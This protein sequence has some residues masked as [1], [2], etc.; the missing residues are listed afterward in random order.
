MCCYS[1]WI[2]C[3]NRFFRPT[4]KHLGGG[5]EKRANGSPYIL[6]LNIKSGKS[7][8]L[9]MFFCFFW[10]Q[11][12]FLSAQ[13]CLLDGARSHLIPNLLA[14]FLYSLLM[15][16]HFLGVFSISLLFFFF[17]VF[18]GRSLVNFTL[19]IYFFTYSHLKKISPHIHCGI[20]SK[21]AGSGAQMP[22]PNPP[23]ALDW[24]CDL[25]QVTSLC[26]S[27]FIC[28]MGILIIT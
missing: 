16:V 26:V 6:C 3:I 18:I 14:T 7:R 5:W 27:P 1:F 20:M 22:G 8:V 17:P 12:R 23:S 24:V 9:S 13:G 4:P 19:E 21:S 15:T 28:K 25:G 11:P 10:K 2:V